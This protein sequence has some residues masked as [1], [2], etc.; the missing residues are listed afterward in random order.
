MHAAQARGK[1]AILL[2]AHFTTLE[3]GGRVLCD[4][5]NREINIMYRP[6]ANA[7]LER[8]LARNRI[9][10]TKRAIQRDDVRADHRAESE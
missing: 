4:Q 5:L 8:F 9:D 3:I 1:G 2:S 7:V 6:T 10:H